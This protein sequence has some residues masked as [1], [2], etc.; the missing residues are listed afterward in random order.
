MG[1]RQH[2]NMP[3]SSDL[4]SSCEHAQKCEAGGG[5]C[6]VRK[7]LIASLMA[8][9][10]LWFSGL[11]YAASLMVLLCIFRVYTR[12]AWLISLIISSPMLLAELVF[13]EGQRLARL[14][15]GSLV[16]VYIGTAFLA[17]V[18][19]M[20]CE[21]IFLVGKE[22]QIAFAQFIPAMILLAYTAHFDKQQVFTGLPV[23]GTEAKLIVWSGRTEAEDVRDDMLYPLQ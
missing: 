12:R 11:S 23:Y 8:L 16:G 13:Y 3:I 14:D 1:F 5:L 17:Y 10:S 2:M 22:R 19:L 6:I 15:F 7:S 20:I 21:K 9:P 4:K 18:G